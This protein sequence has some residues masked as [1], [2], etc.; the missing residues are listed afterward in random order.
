[1]KFYGNGIV[2]NADTDST[3]CRFINGEFETTDPI[4]IDKLITKGY[5]GHLAGV[6][7]SPA[8]E[9]PVKEVATEVVEPTNKESLT[10]EIPAPIVKTIPT[11]AKTAH[12]KKAVKK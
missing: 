6:E 12:V 1:M 11:S 9:V 5:L 3:L 8:V 7:K 10:V 4:V 2:W